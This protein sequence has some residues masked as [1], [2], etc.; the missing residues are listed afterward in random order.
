[1]NIKDIRLDL[2]EY[3]PVD[4]KKSTIYLH[5]TAGS[6]RPDY[7]AQSWNR[8]KYADGSTKRIA[9][10]FIIGGKG[11]D[12]DSTWDGVIVRCFPETQ[13]AWHLGAKGTNGMFDKIS[14]G[15][16][17]CNYGQLTKSKIGQFMTYV[18]TPL[19]ED[20]VLELKTPFRGFKYYH[21]YTDS[22]LD[23]LREL[24]IYLGTKYGINLKMGLQEWINK[25]NLIMPNNLSV[26]QQQQWLNLNGFVGKNGKRLSED[27]VWGENSAFAVNSVGKTA[28]EY[29]PLTKMGYGGIWS[30]SNIRPTDKFDC[31]P[32]PNLIS[33]LKSL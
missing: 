7:V 21:K 19:P 2:D 33:M 14:I 31:S 8:D 25:E 22:Q 16:E 26:L 29:N 3:F 27:G 10:A 18:N 11:R 9:T 23:S 13:W 1:M 5:H 32:Q 20:Q 24:L 15:I 4:V 17:I 6:H 12:N 30:H 28:F